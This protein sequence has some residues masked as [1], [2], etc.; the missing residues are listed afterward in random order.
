M[1]QRL[2]TQLRSHGCSLDPAE[3]R[4][5]LIETKRTFFPG[6]IDEQLVCTVDEGD[7]FCKEVRRRVGVNLPRSFILFQLLSVRK[8]QAHA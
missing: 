2:S 7:E 1:A 5:I 6:W 8:A 4:R 3:F